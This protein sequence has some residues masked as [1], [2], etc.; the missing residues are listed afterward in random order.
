MR[1]NLMAAVAIGARRRNHQAFFEKA[2]A[3]NAFAVVLKNVVFGDVVHIGHRRALTMALAAKVGDVHFER[4]RLRQTG[5]Q[6]I[7]RAVAFHAG[8]RVR[9]LPVQRHAVNAGIEIHL[10]IVV[11]RGALHGFQLFRVGKFFNGRVDV[12]THAFNFT[13][14]G[15]RENPHIHKKR[16]LL[17]AALSGQARV[18]VAFEAGFFVLGI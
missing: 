3:V 7:V 2:D 15:F 5:G 6:N 1:Q 18:R 4:R 12:A 8:R 14:D 11:A 17:A 10:H 13:V 16:D 9:R